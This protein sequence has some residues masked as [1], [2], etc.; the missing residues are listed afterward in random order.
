[1]LSFE[2]DDKGRLVFS[3]IAQFFNKV[4]DRIMVF[5]P[6]S[7]A[8]TIRERVPS[9]GVP[10]RDWHLKSIDH[11]IGG[12]IE[13]EER[14]EGV[15]YRG[16][17]S[18]AEQDKATKIEEGFIPQNSVE[19]FV[20]NE[21]VTR[22]PFEEIPEAGKTWIGEHEISD[23]GTVGAREILEVSWRGVGLLTDSS[24]D[25][26]ALLGSSF[27]I[28]Y[29]DLPLASH[30][31]SFDAGGAADRVLAWASLESGA[32]NWALVARAYLARGPIVDGKPQ[33][34]GQI[35]DIIDGKLVAVPRAFD[36]ACAEIEERE[37]V[38]PRDLLECA[39][40]AGRYEL[41]AE[42]ARNLFASR[43]ADDV[44]SNQQTDAAEPG[45]GPL[46]ENSSRPEPPESPKVTDAAL[47]LAVRNDHI[48]RAKIELA[49]S[50]MGKNNEPNVTGTGVSGPG[51]S[52]PD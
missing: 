47:A 9:G 23:D 45:A 2:R 24:Q 43:G 39:K 18:A 49:R 40:I 19:V 35:A 26:T 15:W 3:A 14:A 48:R 22:A 27:S 10:I 6:G 5:R 31:E 21:G 44:P 8:K 42:R 36:R 33:M 17:I 13:A 12:V 29:Q 25:R 50:K 1:M 51:E 20:L 52:A 38:S 41:R 16:V 28:P 30:L 34:L 4:N 7:F 37:G 32:V 46:S 11:T